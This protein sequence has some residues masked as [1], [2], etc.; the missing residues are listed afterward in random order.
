[1]SGQKGGVY[2]VQPCELKGTIRF[3]IGMSKKNVHNRVKKGYKK[4]TVILCVFSCEYPVVM[5]KYIKEKFNEKFKLIAGKEY[6]EGEESKVKKVFEI[7]FNLY[8][9]NARFVSKKE[10]NKDSGIINKVNTER[11][12][13]QDCIAC[14]GRGVSYWTD[15][16]YGN[17]M[18]C[19]CIDCGYPDEKCQCVRC[20]KCSEYITCKSWWKHND[21]C[22]TKKII[23]ENWEED[24]ANHICGDND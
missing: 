17:C 15:G 19:C 9:D 4:G 18:E 8:K 24:V 6:F 14:R 11:L 13:V 2:L 5:E 20:D 23:G 22:K 12:K 10:K 3:K 7:C 1:M 21:W 16:I